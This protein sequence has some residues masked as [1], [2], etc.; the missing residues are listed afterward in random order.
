[1][2]RLKLKELK[3]DNAEMLSREQLKKVLGGMG[4]DPGGGGSGSIICSYDYT[5]FMGTQINSGPGA[6]GSTDFDT[7]MEYTHSACE[8]A[9]SEAGGTCI[10][11]GC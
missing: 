9:A 10:A 3:V 4:S 8:E 2:K 1:M 11:W 7:C 6:C 5:D